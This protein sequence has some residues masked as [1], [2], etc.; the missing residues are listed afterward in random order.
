M[1]RNGGNPTRQ[2]L[3]QDTPAP[4]IP[5]NLVKPEALRAT[6]MQRLAN[7][8]FRMA[9][10][11]VSEYFT[12]NEAAERFPAFIQPC[13]HG[14]TVSTNG[15]RGS[16]APDNERHCRR[17]RSLSPASP[18]APARSVPAGFP[19]LHSDHGEKGESG[20]VSFRGVRVNH[21]VI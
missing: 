19:L 18:P 15:H 10:D 21:E 3:S 8:S 14:A 2:L 9:A 17:A 12:A 20:E 16:T 5:S 1:I 13:L 7:P 6:V 4:D 11:K